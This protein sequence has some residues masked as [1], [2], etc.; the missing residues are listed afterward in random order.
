M[1]RIRGDPLLDW[2][3]PVGRMLPRAVRGTAG[4]AAFGPLC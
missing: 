3:D 1:D 4:R 2:L